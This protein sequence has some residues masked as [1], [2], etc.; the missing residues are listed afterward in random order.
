MFS[1]GEM[2]TITGGRL[3]GPDTGL[4]SGVS[5]D[6]RTIAPGE[7]FVPL[8]GDRFDGHDY[9]TALAD[10]GL[11][12]CL[13]S[14][15][16]LRHHT[17]PAT[18]SCIAVR[19]TLHALGDL[20][21][22]FRRRFSLTMIGVTGSNG[23]TTTKEMLATILSMVSPGLKTSG[24]LNNLIGLPHMVFRLKPEH[25]WAV[26]EMGMSEP[27]EIDRLA[28]IA[29]PSIGVVLNA[30]QAHLQSMGSVE[31]VAQAK[32]ELLNRIQDGGLAVV[33]ADDPRIASLHQN[34]SAR[35]ISF[36]I[37]RGEVRAENIQG[38]GT[39]GQRFTMLTP[40]GS[41]P[42]QLKTLGQHNIYN[43]LAASASLLDTVSLETIAKGLEACTPYAG[44]FRL[45]QLPG[46]RLLIDD[47]YNANP[48]SC[49]AAL[50]T[51]QEIKGS[52]RTFVALGDMLELGAV[53]Q[54]MHRQLGAQAAQVADRLYLTGGLTTRTA[55]GAQA[56]GMA[57]E[58]IMAA[59]SHDEIA[60][61]IMLRATA[62]DLILIKGSRGM[63]MEKIAAAIRA[64]DCQKD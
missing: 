51:L 7:L 32:G 45:E 14:E 40:K 11:H 46:G 39:E 17:L 33:N 64:T 54:E 4:V 38:L 60:H 42:V 30:C 15:T 31:A 43:A 3:I 18:L 27:G 1:T 50:S 52:S 25:S 29:Q 61:D 23:K 56:A 57:A 6:S 28:A 9:I 16:W 13:C 48:A 62:G 21:A 10:R 63:Q 49:A 12:A 35:R 53:E 2:A 58:A 34:P 22:A 41:I 20:A 55:E 26:L 8:Q 24:N 5:T 19:D 59:A 36:G 47:S 37:R 44:R